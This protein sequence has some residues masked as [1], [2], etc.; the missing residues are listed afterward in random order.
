MVEGGRAPR[1]GGLR[2]KAECRSEEGACPAC[3]AAGLGRFLELQEAC[4]PCPAQ[5]QLGGRQ[6]RPICARRGD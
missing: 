2:S 5:G 6:L 1:V 4:L 3:S